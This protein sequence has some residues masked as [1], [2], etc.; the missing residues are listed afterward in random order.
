MIIVFAT[1]SVRGSLC[2]CTVSLH[3]CSFLFTVRSVYVLLLFVAGC[4]RVCLFCCRCHSQSFSPSHHSCS[5]SSQRYDISAFMGFSSYRLYR[6]YSLPSLLAPNTA[7]FRTSKS[8]RFRRSPCKI[9]LAVAAS[10]I[11]V[12]PPMRC[13]NVKTNSDPGPEHALNRQVGENRE[14]V[15]YAMQS[16]VAQEARSVDDLGVMAG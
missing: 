5:L 1:G 10:S 13:W 14:P 2:D 7:S 9:C 3:D 12:L 15:G 4:P 6:S 8:E 11:S 16:A